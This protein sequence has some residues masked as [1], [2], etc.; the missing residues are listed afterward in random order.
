MESKAEEE[1]KMIMTKKVHRKM[2]RYVY[3]MYQMKFL[4]KGLKIFYGKR[5]VNVFWAKFTVKFTMS[6][7]KD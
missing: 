4:S 6:L 3:F 5:Q 7:S 2:I 1:K